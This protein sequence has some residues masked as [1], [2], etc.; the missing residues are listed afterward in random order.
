MEA[1]T[2]F[3]LVNENFNR[4]IRA[5]VRD[6]LRCFFHDDLEVVRELDAKVEG[7]LHKAVA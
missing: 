7:F 1:V 6:M 4:R 3:E 2:Y 5:G